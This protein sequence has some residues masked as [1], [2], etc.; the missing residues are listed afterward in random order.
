VHRKIIA[1]CVALFLSLTS[2]L[3][4]QAEQSNQEL[5]KKYLWPPI[6]SLQ[7]DPL[8]YPLLGYHFGVVDNFVQGSGGQS[9]SRIEV[10]K[11]NSGTHQCD[12][13]AEAKCQALVGSGSTWAGNVVLPPC[14]SED[15]QTY[16]IEGVRIIDSL[17]S[18]DL[19]LKK[20]LSGP[21]WPADSDHGYM[22]GSEPSLWSDPLNANDTDGYK[23]TVGGNLGFPQP[24]GQQANPLPFKINMADFISNISAYTEIK[25]P[26]FRGFT[27]MK[28]SEG[29]TI[30]GSSYTPGCIWIEN[31]ACGV[32]KDFPAQSKL[33]LIIHLPPDL[34]SWLI[35]RLSDP[36]IQV[37]YLSGQA[38]N[39]FPIER[40]SVMASPVLV[41]L[42][43]QDIPLEKIPNSTQQYL[44][45]PKTALCTST[46]YCQHGFAGG[47]TS[48]SFPFAFKA[49]DVFKD[50]LDQKANLMMPIWS[51]NSLMYFTQESAAVGASCRSPGFKGVVSTNATIYEGNPPAWDGNSLNY[52]VAGV[53]LDS[54][55]N[56]FQGSY[57]LLLNSTY[58]RCLYKFSNAPISATISVSDSAG[59]QSIAT[60]TFSEE[61]GWIHMAARG[62]TFS[63]PMI[64]VSL[65]QEKKN[66][67]V[68]SPSATPAP[69]IASTPS[70]SPAVSASPTSQKPTS[71]TCLKG[72]LTKKVVGLKPVCPAGYKK[73]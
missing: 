34:S 67:P 60:S 57:D 70:S 19:K 15:E 44:A 22:A 43:A 36:T 1:A 58:A 21:E 7:G 11:N 16:C 12:S 10:V 56:V 72:K 66:E 71:I 50:L 20:I 47:N 4:A 32:T 5:L 29:F 35:G 14:K 42:I 17:G 31:G 39:G 52:K 28:D 25:D 54:N 27:K 69:S 49:Y 30:W 46:P 9:M 48:S 26:T 40:V 65:Q 61:Y 41:P 68:P 2:F 73:K 24:S 6:N 3:P 38:Q 63:S 53:H 62:F 37:G 55:G 33:T 8:S 45:D 18:R 64:K 13:F 59:T 51:V 23:V